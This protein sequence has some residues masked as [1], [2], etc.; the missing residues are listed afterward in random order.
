MSRPRI[1]HSLTR[2]ADQAGS[3]AAIGFVPLTFQR[4]LMPRSTM[5]Q[6]LV[7]GLT[8]AANRALVS[9]VQESIQAGALLSLGTAGAARRTRR[10]GAARTLALDVAAVGGGHRDPASRSRA[11]IGSRSPGPSARTGGY[12][13]P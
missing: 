10:D 5:D 13:L 1:N 7:T 2:R 12:W 9:L 4:T 3:L 6:A 8:V 11:G